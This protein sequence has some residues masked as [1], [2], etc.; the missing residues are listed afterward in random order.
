VASD[1]Q[2]VL[3]GGLIKENL[4]DTVVKVP[5]LGDIPVL[6][7]FFKTTST[8]GDRTELVVMITPHIIR[9]SFHI[10]EMRDAIFKSLKNIEKL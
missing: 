6:G 7:H 3:L 9:N 1:G 4:S 2:T 8:G 5:I 10:D